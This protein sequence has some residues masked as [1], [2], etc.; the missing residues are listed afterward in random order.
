M[1]LQQYRGPLLVI[2]AVAVL[3]VASP[4][5]QQLVLFPQTTFFTEF[6]AFGPDHDAAYQSNVT[7]GQTFRLYL[8]VENHLGYTARYNVEMKFR[9]QTQSAPDSFNHTHS[10]LPSLDS[11]TFEVADKGKEEKPLDLSIQYTVNPTNDK[12]LDVANITL[13]GNVIPINSTS[14]AYNTDKKAFSGNLIFELWLYN[15][16][17]NAFEYNQR[18][19]SLWLKLDTQF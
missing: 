19:V 4:A 1:G 13:N 14:I 3:I 8:D 7:S 2:V 10:D 16:T 15:D 12:Q 18:Y 9:N 17:A 6:Y 11:L 5:L